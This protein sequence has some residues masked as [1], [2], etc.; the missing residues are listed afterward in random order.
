MRYDQLSELGQGGSARVFLCVDI[1]SENEVAIKRINKV[2]K[3]KSMQKKF[4]E[5]DKITDC[6]YKCKLDK[7]IWQF[8]Q[9]HF[10]I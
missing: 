9:I 8:R 1:E 3:N 4:K 2:P 7:Y 6:L 5:G 10:A